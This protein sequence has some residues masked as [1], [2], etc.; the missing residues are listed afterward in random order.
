MSRYHHMAECLSCGNKE[1]VGCKSKKDYKEINVC[2]KCSGAFVD[3]WHISKYKNKKRNDNELLVIKVKDMNSVPTVIYNGET[4]EGKVSIA[5]EWETNG[6]E[7]E[8]K[9]NMDLNHV[10]HI[11]NHLVERTIKEERVIPPYKK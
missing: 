3:L 6:F 11:E 9:Q 1:R 8:G 2:P 5:Y 10:Y 4:I 7:K